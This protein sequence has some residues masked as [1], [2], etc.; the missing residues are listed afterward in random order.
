[1][2]I[3]DTHR[4]AGRPAEAALIWRHALEILEDLGYPDTDQVLER[5][6][7]ADAR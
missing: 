5:M 3:G 1:V 2:H 6:I 4:A 7:L